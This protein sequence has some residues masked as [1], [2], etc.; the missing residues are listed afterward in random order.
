MDELC[1][2]RFLL[3]GRII[4]GAG[5]GRDVTLMN[6]YVSPTIA[7][8]LS[9]DD[10]IL[11]SLGVAT[12]SLKSGGGIG[13]DFSTLRPRGAP[14]AGVESFSSG[15]V[16]FM[17]MWNA[18][19]GTIMSAGTRRGAMMGT[20]RIDH[21]D[22][23]EFI[24]AKTKAGILTNFNVSVAV[25]NEFMTA[26]KNGQSF[27]LRFNGIV[28][29]TVDARAL[30]DKILRTT[31]EYAEPGILFIDRIN[32][33]NPLRHI[34]MIAAT[35][36]C[37][38]Q[39]LPPNGA[40]CLGSINLTQFVNKNG[41]I[42]H[43]EISKTASVAIRALD[44]AIT[45]SKF[46]TEKQ[47]DEAYNKRRIGLGITGL[48]D[49]LI[50]MGI[51]YGSQK[52]AVAASEIMQTIRIA[53][54][55]ET[56]RLGRDK[57]SFP[58]FSPETFE[59]NKSIHC[60]HAAKITTRRNSHL[61]TIAPTGTTSILAGNVSSGIEPVFDFEYYRTKLEADG[62]RSKSL[63]KDYAAAL[64]TER[65]G[66]H[67]VT[68]KDLTVEE[69]LIMLSAIQPYI[70]SSISKTIN[71]PAD[72]SFDDFG[73]VYT[74]AFDLGLKGCTTYRPSSTRGAVLESATTKPEAPASTSSQVRTVNDNVVRIA[75]LLERDEVLDGRT[76]KVKPGG[77]DHAM[78]VTIND[79]DVDGRKVPFEIFISSKDV[80]GYAWRVALS[81]M[82][83][84]IMRRGGDL[85]FIPA[86]L[87]AVFDP[88]GGF[89]CEGKY[90]PSHCAAI[91]DIIE[92]H[93]G[94]R[95]IDV[96]PIPATAVHC[97]KCSFGKLRMQEGCSTCIDCGYS[98]C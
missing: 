5:S 74:R 58:L 71:C 41:T 19:C 77:S 48:G 80:D 59:F 68:A 38:E 96:A 87:Q 67:W 23:E 70:D 34:E 9:G 79:M 29:K 83:S 63:V 72:M 57:G 62:S 45:I 53:A 64:V 20:L 55:V 84:A 8:S 95:E 97:P 61:M 86:E 35:N 92:R 26:V 78:Y 46:P 15:P 39:P 49:A 7:D 85:S 91:G 27:D 47:R 89:W 94:M 56:E 40:C 65:N 44:N 98:K 30:W 21:P 3:G 22:I 42:K 6:C 18:M 25:T 10:G 2:M 28:S 43:A 1:S 93:F 31:Y 17:N 32:E 51:R 33:Q 90:V 4:A 11:D 12:R 88:R 52:A 13:M 37:A 60:N 50:M 66:D 76:Y 54:E 75:E 16:S 69:H 24:E 36:P 73:D 82:I 81:R 14:V